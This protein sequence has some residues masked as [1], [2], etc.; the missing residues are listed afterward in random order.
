MDNYKVD[1]E[2]A[3]DITEAIVQLLRSDY[4]TSMYYINE[5]FN[6]FDIDLDKNNIDEIL[7]YIS[8]IANNIPLWGNKG[9]S[10]KEILL[11]GI[12]GR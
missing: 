9:W 7:Y 6:D 5:V 11:K 1:S 10:N 3:Q 8:K 12:E 2:D 4:S